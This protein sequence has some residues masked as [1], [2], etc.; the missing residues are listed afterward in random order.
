MFYDIAVTDYWYYR[1]IPVLKGENTCFSMKGYKQP[2]AEWNNET[3]RSTSEFLLL[4][5]FILKSKIFLMFP[6]DVL[7]FF[8]P[9]PSMEEEGAATACGHI[10]ELFP[11][12]TD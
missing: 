2:P 4:C 8:K 7:I 10:S 3:K 9:K 12:V 5:A 11:N 6:K 1:Q